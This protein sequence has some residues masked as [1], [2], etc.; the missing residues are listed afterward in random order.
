MPHMLPYSHAADVLSRVRAT[1][2]PPPKSFA[3]C[4][5]CH[6][7][8]ACLLPAHHFGVT[9]EQNRECSPPPCA[10]LHMPQPSA[11]YAMLLSLKSLSGGVD[12]LRAHG[13]CPASCFIAPLKGYALEVYF[14]CSAVKRLARVMNRSLDAAAGCCLSEE[15]APRQCREYGARPC[16]R[17]VKCSA[18]VQAPRHA[19]E[20]SASRPCRFFIVVRAKYSEFAAGCRG[21]AMTR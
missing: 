10:R 21:G 9:G 8:R 17:A 1:A 15:P 14:F 20:I 7:P 11:T 3:A 4:G 6:L 12:T 16:C 13:I 19:G 2:M 5:A 18:L